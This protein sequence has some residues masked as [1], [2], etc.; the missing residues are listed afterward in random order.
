V[1]AQAEAREEEQG[2][3]GSTVSAFCFHPRLRVG[4]GADPSVRSRFNG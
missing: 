1:A 2:R 4:G 3:R